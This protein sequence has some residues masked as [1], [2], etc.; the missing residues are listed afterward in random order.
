MSEDERLVKISAVVEAALDLKGEEIVALDVRNLTA[1]ADTFVIVSATSDRRARS[2]ADAVEKAAVALGSPVL[3]VEGY[4]EGRWILVDLGD[5]VV[6]VF[7]EEIRRLYDLER[8]WS[9]APALAVAGTAART[10]AR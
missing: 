10:A 7:R 8:L 9:D 4:H 3:G 5:L 6:H 1:F 2:I